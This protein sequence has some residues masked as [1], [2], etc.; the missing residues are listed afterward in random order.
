MKNLIKVL[1]L[2]GIIGFIA[3]SCD[4]DDTTSKILQVKDLTYNGCKEQ[5]SNSDTIEEYID[6]CIIDSN[7]LAVR[8]VNAIFNCCPEEII[9]EAKIKNSEI[10]YNSF[11]KVNG[12]HCE[13]YYDTYCKIGPLSFDKYTFI[14]STYDIDDPIEF[15][16]EFNQTTQGK[17]I[18][19]REHVNYPLK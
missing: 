18:I 2:F 6:F 10:F 4:E 14:M 9:I 1:F 19:E 13:C 12:C 11:H 7:Y 3:F 8:H 5:K 17:Y 16:I 15:T